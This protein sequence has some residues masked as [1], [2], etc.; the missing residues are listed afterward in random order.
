MTSGSGPAP[1]SRRRTC[2]SKFCSSVSLTT[3]PV[4]E[5]GR[6][7]EIRQL[8]LSPRIAEDAVEALADLGYFVQRGHHGPVDFLGD[9]DVQ[10]QVDDVFRRAS[11]RL[12]VRGLILERHAVHLLRESQNVLHRVV[13]GF[14]VPAVRSLPFDDR[15]DVRVP[16]LHRTGLIVVGATVL[17]NRGT[18]FVVRD[19]RLADPL[20][21]V[22]DEQFLIT[23]RDFFGLLF[24]DLVGDRNFRG[25]ISEHAG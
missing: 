18:E 4:E 19:D 8:A 7:P 5:V 25:R 6:V 13:I 22:V 2:R 12:I 14:N 11:A 9:L 10:V 15:L 24:G 21:S 3:Y 16:N 23:M 17:N 1:G 20:K